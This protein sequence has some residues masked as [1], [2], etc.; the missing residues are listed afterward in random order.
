MIIKNDPEQFQ[1]YLSDASN[2]KGNADSIYLPE[3]E[4]EIVGLLK[5]FSKENIRVTV[6]GNGTGLTGGRVPEGG[7]IISL[8][9]FNRILELNLEKKFV[10]VQPAVVLKDFQD[11]V[12]AQNLFYPPDPTERNCF[13]GATVST[14]ASG[15]RTFKYG[16]TRNYV[17]GLRIILSDGEIIAIERGQYIANQYEANIKTESGKVI[18]IKI[19]NYKMPKTKN[20]A[21]YYC[22]KNMDLIDLFIGSEG[23]LGIISEIKLEL[24]GLPKKFLSCVAFFQTENNALDFIDEARELRQNNSPFPKARALEFFDEKALRFL[25]KDYPNI[26]KLSQAAVWFEE[27]YNTNNDDIVENWVS[28]LNKYNCNDDS[29]W[30]AFDKIEQEKFHEFRHAISWKVNEF[31]SQHNF[32]KVGTDVSVPVIH[33]RSFYYW[34]KETVKKE[35]IDYVVY[36]HFG[37]CHPHLNMLPKNELEYFKS[38]QIYANICAEAVRLEGT[39]SAEHG[40]G[41]LKRDYLKMMYGENNILKM[42]KLK[43][44]FDPNK[45]LNVGNIFDE[46][47]LDSANGR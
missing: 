25:Q 37:D 45:I 20:A 5:K 24:I 38:K 1:N 8:E 34:M 26:P 15:A 43:L 9:K 17:F 35:N 13:I 10:I 44:V 29:V 39:I 3:S 21:G 42:A 7:I 11:F 28:L 46:K 6:S 2:Y 41:K 4:K 32:K 40:I 23:T 12:E 27:D 16:A 30:F 22:K 47:Y 36:G 31:I 19:P 18:S 33:F 14:N